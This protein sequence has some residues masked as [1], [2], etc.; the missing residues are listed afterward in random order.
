KKPLSIWIGRGNLR[1]LNEVNLTDFGVFMQPLQMWCIPPAYKVELGW[2]ACGAFTDNPQSVGKGRPS[3][4]AGFGRLA[5]KK[6]LY[7]LIG[8]GQAIQQTCG[9]CWTR[10]R[11]ELND[12]KAGYPITQ[13]L[14]PTQKRQHVLNMCGLEKL[15]AAVFHKRD[16]AS[17]QF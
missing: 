7:R 8:F 11:K 2:P 15:E 14:R 3:F 4:G 6:R 10:T 9:G 16:I 12:A 5:M 1:Q 17:R 13:I